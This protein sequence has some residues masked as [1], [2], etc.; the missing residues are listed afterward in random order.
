MSVELSEE[1]LSAM[2]A[3]PLNK[4]YQQAVLMGFSFMDPLVQR[5][6]DN[7]QY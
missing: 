4:A 3:H 5:S 7:G 6:P 1:N 2:I